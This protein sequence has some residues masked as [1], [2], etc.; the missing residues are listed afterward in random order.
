[1]TK[2]ENHNMYDYFYY[3]Y[4]H[5]IKTYIP[6]NQRSLTNRTLSPLLYL[7]NKTFKCVN[8]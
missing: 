3:T 1:M 2:M 6:K 7:K 8:I 4:I 5:N